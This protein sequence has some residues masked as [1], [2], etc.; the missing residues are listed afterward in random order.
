MIKELKLKWH[1]S[2][3]LLASSKEWNFFQF[4][5]WKFFYSKFLSCLSNVHLISP[6]DK[7]N[8]EVA[9]GKFDGWV[10]DKLRELLKTVEAEIADY[11]AGGG[12]SE[13]P[14]EQTRNLRR[15]QIDG[16]LENRRRKSL[17]V[18]ANVCDGT[19]PNGECLKNG[20]EPKKSLIHARKHKSPESQFHDEEITDK[21]RKDKLGQ[22]LP[23]SR[24]VPLLMS[25][26]TA[27]HS[28][29]SLNALI[30]SGILA[31]IKTTFRMFG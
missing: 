14:A 28:L 12:G 7:T 5:C 2:I 3:L 11:S 31:L 25:T 29:S 16:L 1:L 13:S 10:V 8:L 21:M 22:L 18:I 24:F 15:K 17:P 6:C 20:E 27:H 23:L 4:F 26:L 30:N 19:S 9:Q